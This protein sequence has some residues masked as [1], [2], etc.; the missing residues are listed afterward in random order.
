MLQQLASWLSVE[1]SMKLVAIILPWPWTWINASEKKTRMC[2]DEATI[3]NILLGQ[4]VTRYSYR[5]YCNLG[6]T[7]I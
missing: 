5:T 3:F 1:I 4:N 7:V 6:A 2:T